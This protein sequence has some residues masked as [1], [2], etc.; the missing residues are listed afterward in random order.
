M[1]GPF[2]L[3]KSSNSKLLTCTP[4]IQ[5]IIRLVIR[6]IDIKVIYGHRGPDI[7][8]QLFVDERSTSD[9]VNQK[10]L[11]QFSPSPAIDIAPFPVLWPDDP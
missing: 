5:R 10:S 1:A 6:Y 7:Q 11:H 9:G 3:S 4:N 8:A 2:T